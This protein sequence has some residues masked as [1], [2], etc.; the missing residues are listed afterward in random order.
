M[1]KINKKKR[2]CIIIPNAFPSK[3]GFENLVY[4]L[5]LALSKKDCDIGVV[6][7]ELGEE[8]INTPKN[9][10]FYPVLR[11]TGHFKIDVIRGFISFFNL[12]RIEKFDIIHAHTIWTAGTISLIGK[13]FRIPQIMTSHGADIQKDKEIGYGARLNKIASIIIWF[14]LKIADSVTVLNKT[15][16]KDA[17]DAGSN[18]SKIKL[19]YNGI[20]LEKITFLG[21][22]DILQQYKITKGDFIVFY[23][24]RLHPKKCPDDLVKAFPKVVKKV[25]NARLIFAGK[26]EEESKLKGL[27][28]DLNLDDKVI[29]A[30]F[31]SE[32]EKWD[33]LKN[34]DVFV[35]PSVVEAFGI[36]IIEA[37]ACEKPV[38]ATDVGP[39]PEIIMDGETGL[40]VPVHSP[41]ELADAII[42]LALDDDKRKGMGKMAR[43]E[44]EER[45]DINKIAN[46]Y[47]KI[48]EELIN[49]NKKVRR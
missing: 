36:T 21:G 35:L 37:M 29:F 46:D 8:G 49:K 48:Y 42:E 13:L 43:K 44:V 16:I 14:T 24:G 9:I 47:L 7:T 11:N 27:V 2:V 22:T 3:G 31:I 18:L 17:I 41:D 39:F 23:L 15:M 32:D 1:I 40:L 33:L 19:V 10:K 38:I 6:C 26:G 45:F 12:L 5:V 28:S 4:D 25:P 20:N 34:C 30:G